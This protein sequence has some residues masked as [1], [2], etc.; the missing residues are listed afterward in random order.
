MPVDTLSLPSSPTLEKKVIDIEGVYV[1]I[2]LANGCSE[3]GCSV[4]SDDVRLTN[5]IRKHYLEH[6]GHRD[7]EAMVSGYAENAFLIEVVNG[8]RKK[9]HGRDEIRAAFRTIFAQH[10]TTDSSFQL[11]HITVE[12]KHGMAIWTARTPTTDFPQSTDT[13][14][15]NDDGKIIKQFF[16]CTV[17]KLEV[18]WFVR[19]NSSGK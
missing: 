15:F 16:A 9:Y 14:V 10:P 8:E 18:P 19:D 6:F 12:A 7:L 13:F 4:E 11:K 2:E 1:P 17:N 3:D 5:V